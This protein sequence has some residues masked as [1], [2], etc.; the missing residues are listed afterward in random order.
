M[1]HGFK[2]SAFFLYSFA[3][4]LLSTQA[5][6]SVSEIA[7]KQKDAVV[8]IF[9]FGK[10][11]DSLGSGFVI[12]K[13]G[14]VVTN[15]HVAK[16]C[17]SEKTTCI[18]KMESGAFFP[19]DAV[20]AADEG[21]DLALIK[22][23]GKGLPT[24]RLAREQ[25]GK[26]GE[27]VV[28]IGSPKGLETTVSDGI[29]SA[30][31]GDGEVLQITAPI[32]PGS[33]G[34]PVFNSKG[35][36][37]GVATFTTEGQNLNFAIPVKFVHGLYREYTA[38]PRTSVKK[39][40]KRAIEAKPE[41]PK[42]KPPKVEPPPPD[43]VDVKKNQVND[44]IQKAK[45]EL[46]QNRF[47]E[48]RLSCNAAIELDPNIAEPFTLR[49]EAHNGLGLFSS[50]ISDADRAI[51]IDPR[52]DKAYV[53]RGHANV[54]LGKYAD[55]I[56]DVDRA[57]ALNP[58]LAVAYNV[59]SRAENG[60]G[61]YNQALSDA[62]RA[63]SIDGTISGPYANRGNAQYRLGNLKEALN[64]Y[65]T[66]LRINPNHATVYINRCDV[67]NALG[68]YDQAL[69]DCNVAIRLSPRSHMAYANRGFVHYNLKDYSRA[70]DDA[71]T[72]LNLK[73]SAE[74]YQVRCASCNELKKYSEA[75]TD[76]TNAIKLRPQN[77]APYHNRGLAFAKM[78]EKK[79]AIPDFQIAARMGLKEAQDS[80]RYLGASW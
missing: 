43:P 44:L 30:I 74:A 21:N 73:A 13:D 55:A 16:S 65:S 9:A 38:A 42:V 28:V 31:R 32:S 76:C 15:Y 26:L 54:N 77:P 29:V 41:P 14:V 19:V 78:G 7:L 1:S 67:Y 5:F 50:A 49:S 46:S 23:K 80:L 68:N 18:V 72:S 24:V 69:Q 61:N 6:A 4:I 12:N 63:I 79:R 3:L 11:K 20:V 25:S 66:A 58:S 33:S 71:S 70:Y 75:V 57:L 45:T 62:N 59:R 51:A 52:F 36:V 40:A 48:A 8:T 2:P 27:S 64:D 10:E 35:E 22:V 34:S 53:N 47:E 39:S 56:K 60:L 37:I 17:M